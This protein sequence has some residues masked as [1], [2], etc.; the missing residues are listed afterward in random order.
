MRAEQTIEDVLCICKKKTNTI[1][2]T[3]FCIQVHL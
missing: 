3:M 1:Y 2:A